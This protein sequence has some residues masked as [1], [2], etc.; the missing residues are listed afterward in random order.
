M[1]QAWACVGTAMH[2]Y[3]PLSAHWHRDAYFWVLVS[4][5]SHTVMSRL[6]QTPASPDMPED[7]LLQFCTAPW[8]LFCTN[9]VRA[10]GRSV[11]VCGGDGEQICL[12]LM[13]ATRVLDVG[14]LAWSQ[15]SVSSSRSVSDDLPVRVPPEDSSCP[16][17]R[18]WHSTAVSERSA[19][20]NPD[21]LC[22]MQSGNAMQ[23]E[24]T[25]ATALIPWLWSGLLAW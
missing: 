19:L 16:R 21:Y 5:A 15:C 7:K 14:A 9:P 12:T 23:Q 25:C 13:E 3:K 10:G 20:V 24:R 4:L 22:H 2:L 6:V 18:M 11:V 1:K 17:C 8:L